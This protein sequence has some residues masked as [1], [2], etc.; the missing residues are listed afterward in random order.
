MQTERTMLVSLLLMPLLG[1]ATGM[2]MTAEDL[3]DLGPGEGL[4]LG[5]VRIE[6][7]MDILGRTS[8][9]LVVNKY[10]ENTWGNT[11]SDYTIEAAR[12][13]DEVVFLTKMPAGR[14]SFERPVQSGL[15]SAELLIGVPFEIQAGKTVYV[16][17]I[18]IQF[19]P[20]LIDALTEVNVQVED[21]RQATMD[22]AASEYGVALSDVVTDLRNVGPRLVSLSP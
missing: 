2:K 14:Y 17:R 4:V 9:E 7:G 8:W 10:R 18:L 22:R 19:P 11:Y 6:G 15:S 16:G 1:C 21:D 13:G 20:G 12:D 5:S 3:R